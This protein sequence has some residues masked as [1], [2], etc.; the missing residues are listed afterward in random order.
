M[1]RQTLGGHT[2]V[3]D[4]DRSVLSARSD[5]DFELL[6]GDVNT[7]I[8]DGV[9]A[10]AFLDR[11][12]DILFR[13]MELTIIIKLLGSVDDYNRILTQ[14]LWIVYGQ[15]LTV[16]P[17]TK[18]FSP[19]QPYPS[20]VLA[21]IRLPSLLG[22]FYKWKIIEAIG[23]LIGKVVKLDV[24][25]NNQTRG[26]F[27]RLVV[28]INLEKSL[29]SQVIVDGAVQCVKYEAILTVC[30]ACAL[31][32]GGSMD[33]EITGSRS[34]EK[35][36]E[37]RPWILVERKLSRRDLSGEGLAK[38]TKNPLGSR[39]LALMVEKDL[40]DDAGLSAGEILGEKTNVEVAANLMSFKTRVNK[41]GVRGSLVDASHGGSK[42]ACLQNNTPIDDASSQGNLDSRNQA[43]IEVKDLD[44]IKAHYNI[45]FDESEGFIVPISDNTLDPEY[46]PDIVS[47]LE[48]R[49]SGSKADN[50][51]AKLGFQYSHR[52][53]AIG[54]SR[55][56]WIGWKYSVRLKVVC[57]HPSNRQVR[58]FLWND[59]RSRNLLGQIP[60]IAIGYFN[61]ILSSSE[62]SWGLYRGRR[63]PYFSDFVDS[64]ELHDLGF[65]GPPF[66][67]HR[68]SLIERLDRALGNKAWIYNFPNCMVSYIPKIK[69]GHRLLLLVLNLSIFFPQ[70]RPFR[71]LVRW[72]EHPDFDGFLKEN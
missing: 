24:Q 60:W 41:K 14:G 51:I 67:W 17:W 11:I 36:P 57:S 32:N 6:E 8:I 66:T 59:L 7:T 27:T 64:T 18:H 50:I 42:H 12:K 20:V 39:F 65:R 52:V 23:G 54:F 30:F 69:S 55:G 31:P 10:I 62:K 21:W 61:T 72:A 16:Q 9:P 70:R 38:Q 33:D 13:E 49:V 68:G 35:E 1:E 58:Q 48:S 26:R 15:Y 19:S 63:C 37:F 56:I 43:N 25:T 40:S 3:S 4:S 34:R 29:I 71:F 53:E 28:Y 5:Y 22:Y 44:K 2:V 47:L 46:K 45:V